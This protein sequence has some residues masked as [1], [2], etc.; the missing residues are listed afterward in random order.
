MKKQ[1]LKLTMLLLAIVFGGSSALAANEIY[2]RSSGKWTE[3]DCAGWEGTPTIGQGKTNCLNIGYAKGET[4]SAKKTFNFAEG[5]KVTLVVEFY[6]GRDFGGKSS[7][8]YDYFK[9][10]GFTLKILSKGTSGIVDIDGKTTEFK[11][12]GSGTYKTTLVINQQTGALS[13][14]V[15][16]KGGATGMATS[17]TTLSDFEFGHVGGTKEAYVYIKSLSI[18]E[19]PTAASDVKLTLNP[20]EDYTYSTYTPDWDVDFT[21]V[22]DV[23]AYKATVSGNKVLTERITGKVRAGE[24]ILIK[25][26]G[27]VSSTSIP[28]TT[29]ATPLENNNLVGVITT[30][31]SYDKFF[32]FLQGGTVYILTSDT[33]FQ[34]VNDQTNDALAKGRAF[35]FVPNTAETAAKS[36]FFGEVTGINGVAVEKKADNAI[37]NLQGMRIKTPTKGLYIINGKKYRF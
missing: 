26:V 9:F 16:D 6:G 33:E 21:G 4:K 30:N 29:G 10:G 12:G 22:T 37:Y 31:A 14:Y 35:L 19:E 15:G 25:N 1:M 5:S 32:K 18:T 27:H 3:A 20:A 8:E 34:L 13:Y 2:S 17:T 24:G 11:A 36:L 23:E 28:V 7:N